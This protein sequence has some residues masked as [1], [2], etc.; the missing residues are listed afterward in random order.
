MVAKLKAFF[1]FFFQ[2]F[3]FVN[4]LFQWMAAYISVFIFLDFMI[5][6]SFS[7]CLIGCFSYVLLGY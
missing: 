2:A 4:A 1:F 5:F 6:Y 3:F 7:F